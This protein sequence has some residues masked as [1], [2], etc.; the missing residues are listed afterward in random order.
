MK[1]IDDL[2]AKSIE[3]NNAIK[4]LKEETKTINSILEEKR[5]ITKNKML[6]DLQKYADI[7]VSL[8][9]TYILLRTSRFMHYNELTR[10]LGIQIKLHDF[11]T[12]ID[13]GCLSTVT[14]GFYAYHSIGSVKSGMKNEEILNGFYSQW[15]SVASELDAVF[16][17]EVESILKNRQE[18]AIA[19]RERAIKDLTDISNSV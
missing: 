17:D 7:M 14:P 9:I 3:L 1:N 18:M 2:V 15:N 11:G 10:R 5:T 8:D 6:N 13:L 19:Q 16:F 12:Q 4:K